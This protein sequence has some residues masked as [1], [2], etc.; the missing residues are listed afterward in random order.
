[1]TGEQLSLLAPCYPETPVSIANPENR[2]AG[3]V[4]PL[5]K[6]PV[7]AALTHGMGK[8]ARPAALTLAG[9]PPAPGPVARERTRT[10]RRVAAARD[11]GRE[12]GGP[13]CIGCA[14]Y[15]PDILPPRVLTGHGRCAH[16][17][18]AATS[19]DRQACA[20]YLFHALAAPA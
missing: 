2:V 18:R 3:T 20:A 8:A 13:A 7:A 17:N 5:K 16:H 10:P 1:M 19:R 4:L 9:A 15:R 12:A 11:I 14:H 6:E